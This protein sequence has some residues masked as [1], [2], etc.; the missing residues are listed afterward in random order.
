[1]GSDNN[2]EAEFVERSPEEITE[3]LSSEKSWLLEEVP[4]S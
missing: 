3:L 1:M 4:E 2:W